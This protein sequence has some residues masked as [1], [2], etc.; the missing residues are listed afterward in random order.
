MDRVTRAVRS[1]IMAAVRTRGSGTTEVRMAKVLRKHGFSGFRR[2]W[3]V[4]GTPDFVWPSLKVALFVD[5][6]FWHGC[7]RCQRLSKSNLSFWRLKVRNNK[8]RDRRVAAA[9]RRRGWKVLRVWEC[10]VRS[11]AAVQKI[12]RALESRGFRVPARYGDPKASRRALT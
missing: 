8:A 9:L 10:A 1:R 11:E 4:R 5:G 3:K 2:H 12:K 6:C 7:P